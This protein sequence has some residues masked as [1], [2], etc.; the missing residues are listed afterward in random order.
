MPGATI[1]APG[2]TVMMCQKWG[3]L[4]QGST[5]CVVFSFLKTVKTLR[6]EKPLGFKSQEI[7]GKGV[8]DKL[9]PV[10]IK[11]LAADFC[12]QHLCICKFFL[13]AG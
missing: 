3:F 6:F 1:E 8:S 9:L 13:K 5:S 7:K 2:W 11:T 4:P 10:T 12:P